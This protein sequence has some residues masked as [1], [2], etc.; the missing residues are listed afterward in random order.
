MFEVSKIKYANIAKKNER[1][2]MTP[3]LVYL[4]QNGNYRILITNQVED[5][6]HTSNTIDAKKLNNKVELKKYLEKR[7]LDVLLYDYK[8][9]L[10]NEITELQLINIFDIIRFERY[11]DESQ[12]SKYREMCSI[13]SAYLIIKLE[14]P[15]ELQEQFNTII[16]KY[17]MTDTIASSRSSINWFV[18]KEKDVIDYKILRTFK[19]CGLD[20][21]K[22]KKIGNFKIRVS[23]D[24]IFISEN[25]NEEQLIFGP[26]PKE[27]QKFI[28]IG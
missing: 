13:I 21:N 27:T 28:K 20:I 18:T 1:L 15:A 5:I 17:L 26:K 24:N 8:F 9:Q 19:A 7:D 22:L 2:S 3:G 14:I 4:L 6:S 10:K 12:R 16:I 23:E 25:K 11:L